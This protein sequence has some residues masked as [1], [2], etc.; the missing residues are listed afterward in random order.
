[1]FEL[2]FDKYLSPDKDEKIDF[3]KLYNKNSE[4]K[5]MLNHLILNNDKRY[6]YESQSKNNNKLIKSKSPIDISKK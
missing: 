5:S 2:E 1:M 4:N 3:Y 6:I